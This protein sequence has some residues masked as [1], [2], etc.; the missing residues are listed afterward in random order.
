MLNYTYRSDSLHFKKKYYTGYFQ[1]LFS[2]VY[3]FI[4]FISFCPQDSVI[5]HGRKLVAKSIALLLEN[6]AHLLF[7]LPAAQLIVNKILLLFQ[8]KAS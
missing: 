6:K 2:F 3:L 8:F 1:F 5:L 7:L 4:L